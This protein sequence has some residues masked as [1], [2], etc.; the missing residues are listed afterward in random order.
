MAHTITLDNI[1]GSDVF[2]L[3]KI[4]E[5]SD[6]D[7]NEEFDFSANNCSYYSHKDVKI[8]DTISNLN[9]AFSVLGLNCRGLTS[10]LDNLKLLLAENSSFKY[11]IIG[12]PEIH[13]IFDNYDYEMVGYTLETNTRP[14]RDDGWGGVGLY[15]DSSLEYKR[16][17]DLSIF[18]PHVIETLF[19]E[20]KIKHRS[21]ICGSIYRPNTAPKADIDIFLTL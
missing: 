16:R 11:D 6:F 18:I 5:S 8:P 13:T 20:I 12:L 19:V 1:E 14:N 2:D 7:V 10:G 9:D 4:L 21:I 15:I 3:H 17:N